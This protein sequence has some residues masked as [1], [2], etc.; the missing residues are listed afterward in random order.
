MARRASRRVAARG[1]A[2]RLSRVGG[3]A[4]QGRFERGSA[5]TLPMLW[6]AHDSRRLDCRG[7]S[8]RLV[9][10]IRACLAE[11]RVDARVEEPGASCLVA[12]NAW[13]AAASSCL[14]AGDEDAGRCRA[15]QPNHVPQMLAT[16]SSIRGSPTPVHCIP[17][18]VHPRPAGPRPPATTGRS[19]PP[20]TTP[21]PAPT[22][23]SPSP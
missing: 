2:H 1:F 6:R 17:P 18:E 12:G 16:R 14:R 3:R 4:L 19:T 8:P 9:Q 15:G 5:C 10:Q 7:E 21:G 23:A 13:S 11:A 20:R 22:S